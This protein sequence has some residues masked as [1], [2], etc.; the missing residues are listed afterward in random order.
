MEATSCFLTL[1]F[2]LSLLW[3]L[4][5]GVPTSVCAGVTLLQATLWPLLPPPAAALLL[6]GCSGV[7]VAAAR[8][9][10]REAELLRAGG[11]VVLIT[12]ESDCGTP[13]AVCSCCLLLA[14]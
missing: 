14:V 2:I 11:R 7:L 1:V 5:V 9:S 8:R 12:G 13:E 4:A 3:S 6:L 10:R